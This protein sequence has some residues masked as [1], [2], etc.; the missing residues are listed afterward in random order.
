MIVLPTHLFR[1]YRS[2][3]IDAG[4][5]ENDLADYLKLRCVKAFAKLSQ[6]GMI[7]IVK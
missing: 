6:A 4:V 3:C 7:L 2:F 5:M 1:Q